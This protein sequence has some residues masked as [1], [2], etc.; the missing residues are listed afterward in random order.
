MKVLRIPYKSGW[1]T[2]VIP[3]LTFL[4]VWLGSFVL[5]LA[6][7]NWQASD[8]LGMALFCGGIPLGFAA[9]V[10]TYP[11]VMRLAAHG[12]GELH[13]EGALLRWRSGRRRHQLDLAQGHYAE[14]AA[15]DSATALTLSDE[16]KAYVNLYFYGLGRQEVQSLFPAPFFIDEL[17]VTPSMGSWGF[18][19]TVDD[20]SARD[21]AVTL[22]EVLWS[23]RQENRYF[24]VYEKFPWERQPQPAFHHIRLI[25][26]EK[27]SPEEEALIL[28]L[29]QQFIDG[30]DDL[31]V[32]LTP[33]YLVAW[34]YKSLRSTLSGHP[35]YYC[36]MP[37][38]DIHAEVSMPRPDWK[39]FIIGHL[40]IEALQELGGSGGRS[41]YI[42]LEDRRYLHVR[43]RGTDGAPLEL[44]FDWY[45]TAKAIDREKYYEAECVVKFIQAMRQ[46][47]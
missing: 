10:V 46:H 47:R 38:G 27:R 26:W 35:D 24:R 42:P 7:L 11:L 37:L 15:D 16:R 25:E 44:A 9:A 29:Q 18:E 39:P 14:I 23:Q 6:L 19:T 28:T 40:V 32:R 17:V 5:I 1:F 36:L 21:F 41:G 8:W 22:L 3:T 43:G 12:R 31:Y 13:L 2:V 4:V 30:L 34:V 20:P 33:D 45:T